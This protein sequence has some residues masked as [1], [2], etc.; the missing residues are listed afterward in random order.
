MARIGPN[1]AKEVQYFGPVP[2]FFWIYFVQNGNRQGMNEGRIG[3][4]TLTQHT[5]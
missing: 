3:K 2:I 4:S 1:R 5:K